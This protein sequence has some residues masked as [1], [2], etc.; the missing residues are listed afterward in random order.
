MKKFNVKLSVINPDYDPEYEKEYGF[1]KEQSENSKFDYEYSLTIKDI[2]EYRYNERVNYELN[3][4]VNEV[5][6]SIILNNVCI[7]ELLRDDK[8]ISDFIVSDSLISTTRTI[9]KKD[10]IKGYF[11]FYLKPN[12][13]Y[14]ELSKRVYIAMEEI[15]VELKLKKHE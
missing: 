9:T 13:E 12:I 6:Q 10:S 4:F 3:Y 14:V 15:P 1:L 7:L 11:Y 2:S 8:V 5:K